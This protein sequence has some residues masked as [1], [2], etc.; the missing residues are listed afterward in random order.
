MCRLI[1]P[2]ARAT[3]SAWPSRADRGS[4]TCTFGRAR[5]SHGQST[6]FRAGVSN[7]SECYR[8][9]HGPGPGTHSAAV[10][11]AMDDP[12]AISRLSRDDADVVTPNNHHPDSGSL[13][14]PIVARAQDDGPIWRNCSFTSR[15]KRAP[16][17]R[18]DVDDADVHW[19]RWYACK[20]KQPLKRVT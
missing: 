1:R 9:G 12:F 18:D 4:S 20:V 7:A 5:L 6:I 14:W 11:P 10:I 8:A 13:R 17:A 2:G 3:F 15:T 16:F 19:S